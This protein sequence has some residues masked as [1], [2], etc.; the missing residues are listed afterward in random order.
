MTNANGTVTYNFTMAD[1]LRINP[2]LGTPGTIQAAD[3][4]I[5]VQGVAD[6]S[7]IMFNSVSRCLP[8]P[9]PLRRRVQE[10]RLEGVHQPVVQE[11]GPVRQLLRAPQR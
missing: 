5:D 7:Q 11:P 3:V 10:R 2:T 1:L 9:A 4:A 8:A 6:I